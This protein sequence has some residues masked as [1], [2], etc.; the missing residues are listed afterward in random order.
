MI[1]S[2]VSAILETGGYKVLQAMSGRE[3]IDLCQTHQGPI[4]LALL[5][6]IMPGMNGPELRECLRE[7][8]PSVRTLFMS[9]YT[10]SEI[11]E[12]GIQA[13]TGD[14]LGK[15]FTHTMLLSRVQE[16]LA[17]AA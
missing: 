12:Q 15:P 5:D 9:G 10:Y 13:G 14:Y 7:L 6:V 8:V 3:A 11:V 1:L 16:T 2:L 17:E 4:H